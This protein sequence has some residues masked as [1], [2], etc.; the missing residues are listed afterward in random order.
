MAGG[1]SREFVAFDLETTGL[2]AESDRVVEIGAVRFDSTG[3]ELGRFE[4]LIRGSSR[5]H[6]M[7]IEIAGFQHGSFSDRMILEDGRRDCEIAH[8]CPANIA[9]ETTSAA[10]KDR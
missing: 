6:F 9:Q 8:I 7:L 2:A 5:R 1:R 10:L 4:R 3:R